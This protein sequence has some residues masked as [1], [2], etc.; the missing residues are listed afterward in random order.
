MEITMYFYYAYDFIIESDFPI[1]VFED[2]S[3]LPKDCKS[4]MIKIRKIDKREKEEIINANDCNLLTMKYYPLIAYRTSKHIV[5][6]CLDLYFVAVSLTGEEIYI[7]L[8]S[9]DS[10]MAINVAMGGALS[11]CMFLHG[12]SP[13]HATAVEYNDKP[14]VFIAPSKTGKSTLEHFFLNKGCKSI[15][16]DVLPVK[17]FNNNGYCF[18]AKNLKIKTDTK[19]AS[20]FNIPLDIANIVT[21]LEDKYW[22]SLSPE[23]HSFSNHNLNCIFYLNP[24]ND[25]N[26]V[27]ITPISKIDSIKLLI[28]NLHFVQFYPK[29]KREKILDSVLINFKNVDI[30]SVNYK[31][32]FCN[33]TKIIDVIYDF[34]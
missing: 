24:S 22:L 12:Y 1:P 7:D 19:L 18:S 8:D 10:Q 5:L 25:Y 3:T 29:E 30:Y 23:K 11:I 26:D 6:K 2:Y 31:K 4:S 9:E 15:A 20:I 17:F 32:E 33:I 34:I 27:F 13:L 16:D 14:L 28:E 21:P